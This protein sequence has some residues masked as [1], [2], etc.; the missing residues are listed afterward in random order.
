LEACSG[1]LEKKTGTMPAFA[2]G[3]RKTK[4]TLCRDGRSQDLTVTDFQPAVRHLNRSSPASSKAN[5]Y[6]ST[7][8]A[9]SRST[10]HFTGQEVFLACVIVKTVSF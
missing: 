1:N 3:P 6:I 2:L 8:Q 9:Y 10:E 4:K 5:R 7:M